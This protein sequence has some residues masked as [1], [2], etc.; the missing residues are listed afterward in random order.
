MFW[1]HNVFECN[2][3]NESERYKLYILNS[4]K[5]MYVFIIQIMRNKVK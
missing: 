2:R 1:E 3:G 4:E 5:K